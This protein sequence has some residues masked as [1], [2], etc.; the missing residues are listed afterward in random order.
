ML[1]DYHVDILVY[2]SDSGQIF[3]SSCVNCDTFANMQ[4]FI[5]S[6]LFCKSKTAVVKYFRINQHKGILPVMKNNKAI[7]PWTQLLTYKPA[8][9]PKAAAPKSSYT[10]AQ[11]RHPVRSG[12]ERLA[13]AAAAGSLVCRKALQ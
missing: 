1:S 6:L 13:Q 9:A 3:L 10:E 8:L 12:Q 4:I 11:Y 7:P 5:S 2:N